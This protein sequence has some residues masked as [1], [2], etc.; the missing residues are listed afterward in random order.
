MRPST[1]PDGRP[2]PRAPVRSSSAMSERDRRHGLAAWQAIE[3]LARDILRGRP[4]AHLLDGRLPALDLRLALPLAGRP[5][6]AEAFAAS[7]A[8]EIERQIDDAIEAQAAFQPG[9]AWCHR[10]EAAA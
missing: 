7:L 3:R 9:H 2:S 10:C 8:S 5:E 4:G 6:D 1:F